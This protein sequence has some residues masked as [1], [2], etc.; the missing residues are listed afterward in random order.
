[1][2]ILGEGIGYPKLSEV[3]LRWIHK[4]EDEPEEILKFL[5]HNG[6]L[7]NKRECK[8]CLMPMSLVR[9]KRRLEGIEW[10][11]SSCASAKSIRQGSMFAGS[12]LSIFKLLVL[13]YMWCAG[14]QNKFASA[15]AE[16]SR[17]IVVQWF[18]KFRKL[19]RE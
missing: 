7:K 3:N 2:K 9:M 19:T 14:Y 17:N 12:L 13:L 1:M 16:V 8:K 5:A 11:C 4:K 15:E 18:L 6:L 10:R